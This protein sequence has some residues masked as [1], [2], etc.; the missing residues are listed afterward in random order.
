MAPHNTNGMSMDHR[1]AQ[2]TKATERYLLGEMTE[3]ERFDFESHYFECEECAGDV[4]A[5]HALSQGVQAV[6][7]EE[8]V[9]VRVHTPSSVSSPAPAP[10]TWWSGWLTPA[11]AAGFAVVAAYQGLVVIPGLRSQTESRA[12][13]PVV[14]R[15]AAR[16]DEQIVE[17]FR[18]QP[19]TL[20]SLDVNNAEPGTPLTY[21]MTGPANARIANS[22]KAPPAGSPLIVLLTNTEFSGPGSWML[23]LRD[24]KGVEVS[25]FPFSVQIK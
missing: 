21:E 9:P 12:M 3:P 22:A 4:R 13:A 5:V 10:R 14:L 24:T 18:D 2:S 1:Q 19:I 6:C 7:A 16:G 8:P 23:I 17:I 11:F 25:R 15:A 20:L